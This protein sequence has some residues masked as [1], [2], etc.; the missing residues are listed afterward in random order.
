MRS[1]YAQENNSKLENSTSIRTKFVGIIVLFSIAVSAFILYGKSIP[2][3]GAIGDNSQKFD[4]FGRFIMYNFDRAKPVSNFLNGLGGLWGIPMW[5]FY[6]NRGQAVASF[7]LQNKDGAIF[8]FT[9]ANVAYQEVPFT[10]FRTFL[11]AT[12][13]ATSWKN[14]P[15]FPNEAEQQTTSRKMYIG[16]SDLEIEEV[17][18]I[19]GLQTNIVYF[20]L[21]NHNLNMQQVTRGVKLCLHHQ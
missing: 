21:F 15:F 8:K 12:R 9:T 11:K 6:V 14:M 17:N 19:I 10:G 16:N 13:G 20:S 5:C 1:L 18:N 2:F 4:E 7:G 3:S